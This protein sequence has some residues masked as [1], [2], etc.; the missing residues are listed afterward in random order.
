MYLSRPLPGL[1]FPMTLLSALVLLAGCGSR[2]EVALWE[3]PRQPFEREIV[4]TAWDTLWTVGGTLE[5]TILQLP[6][7]VH[8][9]GD[10][11]FVLDDGD[12]RILAFSRDGVPK[13]SFGGRGAGP[14]EFGGVRD[15]KVG[16]DGRLYAL[17]PKNAR[18]MV[19]SPEG[20][21]VRRVPLRGVPHAEQFAPLADGTFALVTS[22]PERPIYVIDET[23]EVVERG[24][25]PW[26]EFA[27]LP[28][29]VRQ[30]FVASDGNAWAYLFGM[31]NGWF[32]FEGTDALAH[33]GRF[34]E[35]TAFPSLERK[36][37]SGAR[38]ERLVRPSCSACSVAMQNG[39]V[40]VLFGGSGADR[41]KI[42][43]TYRWSDGEYLGTVR[44]PTGAAAVGVGEEVFYVL[45]NSPYP[46]LLALRPR[47][48][49]DGA[50]LALAR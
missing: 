45:R 7:Q 47:P 26:E 31:G 19:L 8:S 44:L 2:T 39:V 32:S 9:G 50:G 43:D 1:S 10:A 34:V 46:T 41:M 5:D 16:A 33:T 18:I 25:L 28:F 4:E 36:S 40:Y 35:H 29:I 48:E 15:L 30:G 12:Q 17:D 11:V 24:D 20:T 14:D 42:V 22:G 37:G 6:R 3:E 13:W 27:Q 23:G 49:R 38:S 21:V